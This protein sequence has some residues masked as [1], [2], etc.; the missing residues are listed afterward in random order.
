MKLDETDLKIIELLRED[1]RLT[2]SEIARQVHLTRVAARERILALEKN[3]VILGY[4]V[5][6]NSAALNRGM[7]IFIDIEVEPCYI[8]NVA[9]KLVENKDVAVVS[10]NTGQSG[11]HVH[12]YISDVSNL[13]KF[14]DNNV[15]NIKGVLNVK[16]SLLIKN[17][18]TNAFLI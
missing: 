15:Y 3:G 11:L 2:Y 7:S 5:Q 13:S 18:K 17:Y 12:A 9:K 8:E 10:Q 1:A 6:I 16:S 4:T 14:L